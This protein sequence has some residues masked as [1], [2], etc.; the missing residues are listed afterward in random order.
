[1]HKCR[2]LIHLSYIKLLDVSAQKYLTQYSERRKKSES[3]QFVNWDFKF[4]WT[5]IIRISGRLG[6]YYGLNNLTSLSHFYF[7]TWDVGP[8]HA[9]IWQHLHNITLQEQAIRL[10]LFL[11]ADVTEQLS[12]LLFT[13]TYLKF[14]HMGWISTPPFCV[15]SFFFLSC[16]VCLTSIHSVKMR[17]VLFP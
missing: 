12:V 2:M 10:S 7:N 6:I 14:N 13:V 9:K 4:D 5:L 11:M 1:M 3:G 16:L 15:T 8:R 17:R